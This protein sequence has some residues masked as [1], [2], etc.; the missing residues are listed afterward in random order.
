MNKVRLNNPNFCKVIICCEDRSLVVIIGIK[1]GS[2][3]NL[4]F[5]DMSVIFKTI[6]LTMQF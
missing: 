2:K 4:N 1:F 5:L 6:L 3:D